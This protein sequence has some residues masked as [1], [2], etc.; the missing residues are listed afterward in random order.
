MECVRM[1]LAKW[2][3]A[4]YTESAL[5]PPLCVAAFRGHM[6]LVQMFC[7]MYP[8]P[9]HIK[10]IHGEWVKFVYGFD[11][12]LTCLN[13]IKSGVNALMLA[14]T[15]GHHAIELFLS[16]NHPKMWKEHTPYGQTAVDLISLLPNPATLNRA[17]PRD[18]F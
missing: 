2:S 16:E 18:S 6:L 13:L 10:T 17:I 15:G 12:C 9:E 11:R 1:L 5:M 3:Y 4:E 14:M 8:P 7:K